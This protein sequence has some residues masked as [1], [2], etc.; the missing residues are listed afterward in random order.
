M[1]E[2]MVQDLV[3]VPVES[4]DGRGIMILIRQ[5]SKS[6]RKIFEAILH[7]RDKLGLTNRF[8]VLLDL[9]LNRN[10]GNL[11]WCMKEHNKAL[12]EEMKRANLGHNPPLKTYSELE[13]LPC[14]LILCEKGKMG[15]SCHAVFPT[16]ARWGPMHSNCS[17]LDAAAESELRCGSR[18]LRCLFSWCGT[19][20]M[21]VSV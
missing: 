19:L 17:V 8:A 4:R 6:G 9:D 12:Y 15:K 10:G 3:N 13:G 20:R 21:S 11:E 14:I 1:T 7:A 2:R 16:R 18:Q 5:P